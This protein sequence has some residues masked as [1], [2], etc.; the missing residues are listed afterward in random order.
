MLKINLKKELKDYT[1]KNLETLILEVEEDT[2]NG[3]IFCVFV[4]E[5]LILLQCPYSLLW[6]GCGLSV[7]KGS[8]V[9][10]G[11]TGRRWNFWELGPGGRFLGQ[12]LWHIL[13]VIMKWLWMAVVRA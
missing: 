12:F 7:P 4:L 2:K 9:Q 1:Q 8:G 3:K 5:E 13:V 11:P 10:G 6:F